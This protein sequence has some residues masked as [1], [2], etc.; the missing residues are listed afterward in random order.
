MRILALSDT[1]TELP[2]VDSLPD[3]EVLVHCGDWTNGGFAAGEMGLVTDWVAA[4][5]ERYPYLLALH[6]NHDIGVRNHHWEGMGVIALDG[7]TWEH[8]AG[9]R[10]HGVALTTAYDLPALAQFWDYMTINPQA[11]VAVWDFEPVDV[12]VAHGPPYG[13]LDQMAQGQRVGSREALRYIRK[14]QPRLYLCGHIHEAAG[15]ARIGRTKV[16]NLARRAVLLEVES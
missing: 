7:N 9:L 5:Q 11:E 13:Y 16:V 1:H 2:P 12:V 3:A 4:A 8:P 14:H 10:F 6:G 15:E